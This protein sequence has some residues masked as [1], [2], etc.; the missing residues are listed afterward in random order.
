[1]SKLKNQSKDKSNE[2]RIIE[3]EFDSQLTQL[4]ID[5]EYLRRQKNLSGTTPPSIFG[6][7]QNLYFLLESVG[8]ARIEGNNTTI[9]EYANSKIDN[10]N[11]I[12]P[13]N[14]IANIEKGMKFIEQNAKDFPLNRMFVSELHKFSVQGLPLPPHGEGDENPGAYRL[15]NVAI[16]KSEHRP[17]EAIDVPRLM[18]ELFCW[19]NEE[20]PPRYDLL[21]VALAHH[22]FVWIHPFTNGNGRTARLFTYAMLVKYGFTLEQGRIVNP[23]A[24]FCSSRSD[25]YRY[26][27]KADTG[28]PEGILEW[29]EYVLGGLKK[30]IE[31]INQLTNFSFLCS[32][33]LIPAIHNAHVHGIITE[34]EEQI[35]Q[36]SLA[37]QEIKLSDVLGQ[38]KKNNERTISRTLESLREKKMLVGLHD[39]ARIYRFGFIDSLLLPFIIRSFG[40]KGFLPMKADE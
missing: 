38:N 34:L 1:M 32:E 12:Y 8:S 13:F 25:Y 16:L 9:I 30:E 19:I 2:L 33:L 14:E 20:L 36:I 18:D 5:L 22:R 31:K 40:E 21:K 10:T 37:K 7:L 6:Q 35:L 27:Q 15:K 11:G 17:P 28:Q 3:P 26:L 23:V 4:I 24:I 29:C 39:R